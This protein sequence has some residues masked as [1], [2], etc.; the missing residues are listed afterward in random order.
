[1][2]WWIHDHLPYSSLYF[3]PKL[4]AFNISWHETP[5][6]RIDSY[7]PP[8]GCLTRLGMKNHEGL[9]AERYVGFPAL[10]S[11]SG[12]ALMSR[13]DPTELIPAALVVPHRSTAQFVGGA[14]APNKRESGSSINYR[15]VHAKTLWRKAGNHRSLESAIN[16]KDGAAGLFA[17]RVRIDYQKHGEPLYVLVWEDGA[18]TG[19]VI[20]PDKG[21]STGIRRAAVPIGIL[22]Q[23]E[24]I[25]RADN[26][27]LEKFF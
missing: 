6:R 22:M 13:P 8:K 7:A 11:E 18:T 3:F 26:A 10:V 27:E 20:K 25:G 15:A 12:A 19:C 9:H 23:W 5:V 2:A 17:H 14:L 24:E 21:S 4:A 16:G 1:M